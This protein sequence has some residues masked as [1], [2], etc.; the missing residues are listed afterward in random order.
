[1]HAVAP[2]T[3]GVH[4]CVDGAGQL[5]APSQ[6]AAAVATPLAQLALRQLDVGY[7]QA[8]GFVPSHRP[9]HVPDPLHAGREPIGAPVIVAHVP[10]DPLALHA[11]HWPVQA[12][13]QQ[14]PSMQNPDEH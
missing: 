11:W 1:M 2:Q 10:T 12:W 7:V 5:P 14:T 6:L 9:A 8:F 4:V 13:L 3:Y